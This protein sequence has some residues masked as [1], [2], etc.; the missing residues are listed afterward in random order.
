[1]PDQCANYCTLEGRWFANC[2]DDPRSEKP[3]ENKSW[4][5]KY[6][7]PN[8]HL[9]VPTDQLRIT[10]CNYMGFSSLNSTI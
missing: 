5:S 7:L 8:A 2:Y 4:G 1:M 10:E 3:K 6:N 9:C